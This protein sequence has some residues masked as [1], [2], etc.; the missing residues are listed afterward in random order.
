MRM[1]EV[2][3]R[4]EPGRVRGSGGK[5]GGGRNVSLVWPRIYSVY[6][7]GEN[8][9]TLVNY[10]VDASKRGKS[11]SL[12]PAKTCG[13]SFASPIAPGAELRFGAKQADPRRMF[14]LQPDTAKLEGIG[15][16]AEGS[17]AEG[18]RRKLLDFWSVPYWEGNG[19]PNIVEGV[20]K[21]KTEDGTIKNICRISCSM[22]H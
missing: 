15:F 8:P 18:I 13:T 11:R 3:G 20:R 10:M 5:G 17:F 19:A 16:W 4:R 21:G 6:G 9:E 2:R 1:Q 12:R 14:R 7:V 22:V